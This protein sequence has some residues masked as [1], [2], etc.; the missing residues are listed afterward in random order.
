MIVEFSFSLHRGKSSSGEA[1]ELKDKIRN[2][3]CAKLIDNY[4][5][6]K[7]GAEKAY[8]ELE[9]VVK[10]VRIAILILL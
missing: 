4:A 9:R 5:N 7:E 2:S 10:L 3:G 6:P 8:Q 1:R